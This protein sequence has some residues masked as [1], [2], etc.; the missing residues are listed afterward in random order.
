VVFLSIVLTSVLS[1][2][3]ERTILAK[4]YA[5]FFRRFGESQPAG[6]DAW[7]VSPVS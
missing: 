5:A 1:F 4:V 7:P 3:L 6:E 2:L